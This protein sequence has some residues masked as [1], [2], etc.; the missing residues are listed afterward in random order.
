MRGVEGKTRDISKTLRT[1]AQNEG[2]DLDVVELDI[3][4]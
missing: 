1:W 4:D 3:T 2:V